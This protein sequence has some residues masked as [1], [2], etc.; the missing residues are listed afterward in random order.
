MDRAP[1]PLTSFEQEQLA[2]DFTKAVEK[3][4]Y[5]RLL[6]IAER[7]EAPAEDI[8]KAFTEAIRVLD[9][10]LEANLNAANEVVEGGVLTVFGSAFVGVGLGG[11]AG[12][13]LAHLVGMSDLDNII[14]TTTIGSGAGGV[15]GAGTGAAV[16]FSRKAARI[17]A[18]RSRIDLLGRA[19]QW[20]WEH[21]PPEARARV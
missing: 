7:T 20:W 14:D 19:I 9:G 8:M 2:K 17:K 6:K 21:M 4:D 1:E 15:I 13:L 5:E 11:V 10:V 18:V 12:R 3:G 16:F